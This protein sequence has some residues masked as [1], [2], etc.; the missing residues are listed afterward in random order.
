MLNDIAI[1][2][3]TNSVCEDVWPIYFGQ[4]DKYAGDL[5]SFVFTNKPTSS[6]KPTHTDILYDE[7]LPYYLQYCNGLKSVPHDYIIYCQEDFFL[8][9]HINKEEILRCLKFLNDSD[10]SFVRLVKTDIG[11]YKHHKECKN[12]DFE[13]IELDKN[14]YCAHATD[15][16]AYSFQM[17]ATLW[18]KSKM[19]ELYERVESQKWLE[20]RRWDTGMRELN[21]KGAY[22]HDGSG[23]EGPY[24]CAPEIWPYICTAIGRGQW[25][26]SVHGD[27]LMKILRE[28]GVNPLIRGT[29]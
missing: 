19:I 11:A 13:T 12:K 23:Q 3:Y 6:S 7:D 9:D 15:F 18:K 21:I 26:L 29:R 28:Y 27:R 24:H 20:D 4:L 16:D 25:T 1:V 2:T 14:I 10:Y 5:D 17:Q 22:Y 8:Q